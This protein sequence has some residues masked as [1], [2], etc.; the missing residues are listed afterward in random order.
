MLPWAEPG[1]MK[2]WGFFYRQDEW[3]LFN[4]TFSRHN[5]THGIQK[6]TQHVSNNF[7]FPRQLSKRLP[8]V[9][10]LRP[11]VPA[12]SCGLIPEASGATEP[13]RAESVKF[14]RLELD[15]LSPP[16]QKCPSESDFDYATNHLLRKLKLL[17]PSEQ[18]P[19]A[20]RFSKR[21]TDFLGHADRFQEHNKHIDLYQ[22][23]TVK[24]QR[25]SDWAPIE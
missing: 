16:E 9:D 1:E 4:S 8:F 3:P 23:Q 19:H 21:S 7:S 12:T 20:N 18:K 2:V 17:R 13:K 25:V 14:L 22:D 11:G 24:C 5:N 15:K 10:T 6:Q